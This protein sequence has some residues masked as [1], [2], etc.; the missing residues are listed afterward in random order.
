VL[1]TLV[2][3]VEVQVRALK[4]ANDPAKLKAFVGNFSGL[5]DELAK[6][7]DK[8]A[9]DS[10]T[11]F[12]LA[13][14]YDI[15]EQHEKAADLYAKIPPPHWLKTPKGQPFDKDEVKNSQAEKEVQTYWYSRVQYARQLR[16]IGGEKKKEHLELANK[17]LNELLQHPHARGQQLAEKEKIFILQEKEI[18]GGAATQWDKLM[19]NP[20]LAK[21]MANGDQNAKESYFD[22]YYQMTY[23]L[24]KY[25]RTDAAKSRKLDKAYLRRAA[26]YIFKLEIASNSEGWELLRPRF[27]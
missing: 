5:V 21:Q 13:R 14:L 11:S 6:G 24:Y 20:A 22:A 8:K 26:D 2:Q 23:C 17:V 7:A 27:V 10:T 12:F 15:L 1:Q 16:Q 25:S 4:K 19:K 9:N 18:Y 3:D